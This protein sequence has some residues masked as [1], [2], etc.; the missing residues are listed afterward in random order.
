VG[1]R[2]IGRVRLGQRAADA[3]RA[4][5]AS[6]RRG[7]RTLFWCVRGGGR[8]SVVLDGRGRVRLAASTAPGHEAR[9]VGRG[10]S[11]SFLRRRF[12]HVPARGALAVVQRRAPLVFGRGRHRIRFVAVA[13][14]RLAAGP[15]RLGAALRRMGF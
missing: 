6:P 9:G 10:D 8:L 4:V 3:I 13:D 5:G 1:R 11:R 2:G 14:R 7:R 15:R 12:A